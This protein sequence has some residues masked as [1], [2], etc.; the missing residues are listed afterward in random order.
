MTV[1]KT[2][3]KSVITT[4]VGAFL[5]KETVLECQSDMAVFRSEALRRLVPFRCTFGFDVVVSVGL[6]LFID[7]RNNKEIMKE[8]AARNIT[9]SDREISYLGRKFVIYLALAH[10]ESL[11]RLRE[12]MVRRGGYILHLD[13]TCEKD[14]PNLFCALDGISE[15]ILDSIKIPSEKK[16]QLVPF[17]QRIKEK[18][19]SPVALVH[20]M[21]KGIISAVEEVFPEIADFIC[22]FHFLRD[23]GKDVLQE[24]YTTLRKR[25][26][27]L[28]VR[29]LLRRKAKYLENKISLDPQTIQEIKASIETGEC[30]TTSHE[31]I[32]LFSAITLIEWVF[33]APFQSSGYGFP[34]DRPHLDFFRRLQVIRRELGNIINIQLSDQAKDNKPLIQVYRLLNDAVKDK[35]LNDLAASLEKDAEVFDR[36]R[37][38]MRIALPEGKNGLNDDGK[39]A[40]MRTIK[41]KVTEFR[42][43]LSENKSGKGRYI[44]MVEQ[45]DK[46]WEKLFADPLR[47]VTSEGKE[48]YIQP[49]RTNNILERFFRGEKRRNRQKSGTAS[50][51][52]VLKAILA[53]T[54]FVQN[55]KQQEYTEIILNGCGNLAERFSQID[56]HL[57]HKELAEAQKCKERIYPV[58][59]KLIK[60]SD[61]PKKISTL[62]AVAK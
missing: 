12:S 5:A 53:E 4:D 16:D 21:G 29:S 58:I 24:E 18:Y 13:G 33:E 17:F 25:L 2:L 60:K 54:P 61:L 19:G 14:S 9:I 35:R 36:L 39:D 42:E 59:K 62:F 22:H 26:R 34:F 37:Q 1:Q 28:N 52:K 8:L 41:E 45:I 3:K 15:L 43:R 51:N 32:P 48:I 20:D 7:C 11:V 40:D 6:A 56:A 10:H 46:Y 31:H 47:I 38:A 49:Q 30:K 57:V 50:L 44:K 23:I 55:L 27:K